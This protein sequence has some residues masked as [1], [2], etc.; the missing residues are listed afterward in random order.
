MRAWVVGARVI[1]SELTNSSALKYLR[2]TVVD[3]AK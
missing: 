1:L 2:I 3:S